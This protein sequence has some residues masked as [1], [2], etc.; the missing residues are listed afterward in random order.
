MGSVPA[1]GIYGMKTCRDDESNAVQDLYFQGGHRGLVHIK[2]EQFKKLLQ[3]QPHPS[4]SCDSD[5]VDAYA[6]DNKFFHY[7]TLPNHLFNKQ[8]HEESYGKTACKGFT[9]RDDSGRTQWG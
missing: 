9:G 8:Y 1:M 7:S 2:R 5:E 6:I 3:G 4:I